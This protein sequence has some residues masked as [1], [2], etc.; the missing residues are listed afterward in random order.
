MKVLKFGGACLKDAEMFIRTASV[1]EREKEEKAIVISAVENVTD[2]LRE[3]LKNFNNIENIDSLIQKLRAMHEEIILTAIQPKKILDSLIPEL[4]DKLKKL[5]RL[6]YGIAY[7]EELTLRTQ[8]LILSFGE[9]LSAC[10][11]KG[12]LQARNIDAKVFETDS[13]IITD[14]AFGSATALLQE[15]EEKFSE[16]VI[17]SIKNKQ[18]PILTGFFG[19][20]KEGYVTTLGRGGSDYSG[21]IAAYALNA[22]A[23]ELWKDVDGFMSADPKIVK[24]AFYLDSLSYDEAAELAYFGAEIIHPRTVEPVSEKNIPIIIKNIFKPEKEGS[25]IAAST[26]KKGE[27]I[28]SVACRNDLGLLKVYGKGAGYRP[29]TLSEITSHLGKI[30]INI[31][32]AT[33]S[34]TCVSLL[35]HK[36]D[37]K[38]GFE[39]LNSVKGGTIEKVESLGEIALI[40]VVGEGLART[41][42][43][44]A[45]IFKAVAEQNINVELISAGASTVAF[46]FTV[47]VKDLGKAVKAVHKEFFGSA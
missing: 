45:R 16:L 9:R 26:F 18:L 31:Y 15:S 4:D 28:K 22:R 6:L 32:S 33:T 1:I 17:P 21:A 39:I 20:T 3:H 44:A 42:G 41:K 37:L 8:D 24:N 30:G 12:I 34:Q 36:N 7:T 5:E 10:V 25:R 27:V 46:H 13:V 38:K 23:V 29:G 2:M 40:C 19:A 11:L 35:L 14:D 43:L 47:A